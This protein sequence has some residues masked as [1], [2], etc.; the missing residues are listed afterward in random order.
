[1][2]L[3]LLLRPHGLGAPTPP[4]ASPTP[5]AWTEPGETPQERLARLAFTTVLC[6]ST[7]EPV[8]ILDKLLTRQ[9]VQQGNLP[10]SYAITMNMDEENYPFALLELQPRVKVYRVATPQELADDPLI[11]NKLVF[12]GSLSS[13]GIDEDSETGQAKLTFQDPRW[14]LNDRYV[15]TPVTFSQVD[16]GDILWQIIA[17]QNA[18]PNGDTWIR[19]GGTTTGTLR[20]RTY[21]AGKE[22]AGLIDDMTKVDGGCDVSFTPVDY[23]SVDGTAAMGVFNAHAERG[24]DRP[25]ALFIS[26]ATL[27]EG[28]SGGLP[29]NCYMRRTRAKT[30]TSATSVGTADTQTYANTSSPYGLLEA[31]ETFSDVSISQ[32]LLDKSVGK[33]ANGQNAPMILEVKNPT[34]EA[35]QP[36]LDYAIGDQVYATCRR[37]GM[38]FFS[39]PVRVHGID[40][41]LDQ[42]G[43]LTTKPTLA[44]LPETIVSPTLPPGGGGGVPGGGIP[45]GAER[46]TGTWSATGGGPSVNSNDTSVMFGASPS[47]TLDQGGASCWM[48]NTANGLS[49]GTDY[50]IST[51]VRGPSAAPSPAGTSCRLYAGGTSLFVGTTYGD[52]DSAHIWNAT[53]ATR[54]TWTLISVTFT[55]DSSSMRCGLFTNTTDGASIVYTARDYWTI[56][57]A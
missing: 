49:V 39:L 13:E 56:T 25:D 55:A 23:W 22:V 12:Y 4:Y 3:L 47:V 48:G 51:Y 7:G 24:I 17:T 29:S 50:T 16:Q 9:F 31:Y 8:D 34:E 37:G 6:K 20:D 38:Q 27:D 46:I 53:Q 21:D 42:T 26:G 54:E 45:P 5:F 1:M 11:V 35:P 18:R 15:P 33:V 52:N 32:T 36:L 10:E 44:T 2:T 14:V 19:Q 43:K 41:T 30:I 28:T 40:I 57:P